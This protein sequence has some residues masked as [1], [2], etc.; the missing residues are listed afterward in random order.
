MS[1]VVSGSQ[2][3]SSSDDSV[4]NWARPQAIE[5]PFSAPYRGWA[6]DKG[7]QTGKAH[8]EYEGVESPLPWRKG[9]DTALGRITAWKAPG[10]HVTPAPWSSASASSLLLGGIGGSD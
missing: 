3:S 6:E 7:V 5:N 4:N 2:F 8:P 9:A 10:G 1:G